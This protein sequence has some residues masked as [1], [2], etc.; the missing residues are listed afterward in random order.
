MLYASMS[1][2]KAPEQILTPGRVFKEHRN[3]GTMD[4]PELKETIRVSG[5]QGCMVSRSDSTNSHPMRVMGRTTERLESRAP[6]PWVVL[7]ADFTLVSHLG[8]SGELALVDLAA[9]RFGIGGLRLVPVPSPLLLPVFIRANPAIPAAPFNAGQLRVL[10][11][12]LVLEVAGATRGH[13]SRSCRCTSSGWGRRFPG[14]LRSTVTSISTSTSRTPRRNSMRASSNATTSAAA[15]RWMRHR[16]RSPWP[17]SRPF[18]GTDAPTYARDSFGGDVGH[19]AA[20]FLASCGPVWGSLWDTRF[21][22]RSHLSVCRQRMVPSLSDWRRPRQR[23]SRWCAQARAPRGGF[24]SDAGSG[25][26]RWRFCDPPRRWA[27]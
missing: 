5:C 17:S 23:S 22:S 14:R 18:A 7:L 6:L 27:G 15:T 10:P 8:R 24:G 16:S 12:E 4:C 21:S 26:W 2:L 3:A 25:S 11:K 19:N 13:C 9:L 1:L 20:S